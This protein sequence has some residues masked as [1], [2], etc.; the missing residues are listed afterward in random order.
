MSIWLALWIVIS[1]VL[2]GFLVWTV[3]ILFQQKA[4]W[5]AF[6]AQYKLRYKPNALM[7]SPE[8][9]GVLETYKVN[10]FIAEHSSE[11]VRGARKL[12]AVE[13][14]LHS[15]VP[16]DGGVASGG[17]VDLVRSLGFQ[18]EIKP[19]HERW[20]KAYIAAGSDRNVLEAYLTDERLEN[21]LKLMRIKN[22]WVIFIFRKDSMLLRIDTPNALS[23]KAYLEKLT[24]LL[25]KAAQSL[26]L[27][28]D[29]VK[30]LKAEEVRGQGKEGSLVLDDAD[31]DVEA[32]S[33]ELE[34]DLASEGAVESEDIE[35]DD[36][37]SEKPETEKE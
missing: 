32:V 17:M 10:Y 27:G 11:D 34:E 28:P 6:A 22:A 3:F 9:D 36:Q 5:K 21:L 25:V 19:G 33:L 31:I 4:V 23:S 12:T 37:S 29:E 24:K 1:L 26:E 13:V 15:S 20:S 30:K 7:H 14:R 16:I 35:G 8:M 18:A 2:M